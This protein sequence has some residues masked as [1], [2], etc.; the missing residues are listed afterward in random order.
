MGLE[1]IHGHLAIDLKVNGDLAKEMDG[2]K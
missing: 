1:F 2:G